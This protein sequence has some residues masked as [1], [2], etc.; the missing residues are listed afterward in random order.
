MLSASNIRWRFRN[1]LFLVTVVVPVV[2]AVIYYGFLASDVYISESKFVVRSPEKPAA[3]G[4]GV[5]LKSAGFANAGDEIYAA[6]SYASSRDALRAINQGN[7]FKIAYTRPEISTIDRF[8]PWGLS[9]SFE[10]LYKY[11]QTKVGLT[12]D[13]ST[14]TAHFP[15]WPASIRRN[16][17]TSANNSG[18][19]M[20]HSAMSTIRCD[21]AS[22]KPSSTLPPAGWAWS[23][24]RRRLRGRERCGATKVSGSMSCDRAA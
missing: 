17:A 20:W 23:V 24:A 15:R 13:S 9:D 8:N 16:G 11:F 1:S 21:P 14:S 3:T 6:Q 19:R 12:N 18:R 7:A 5:I 2:L 22:R 4:L 10:S